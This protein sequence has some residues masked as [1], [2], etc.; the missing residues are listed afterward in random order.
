MLRKGALLFV[1][2]AALTGC[3]V[4]SNQ[5]VESVPAS[6]Q[7]TVSGTAERPAW[8]QDIPGRSHLAGKWEK[9][10]EWTESQKADANALIK[11]W[12][13]ADAEAAATASVKETWPGW[14][15][16]ES[17]LDWVLTY[18][19][20]TCQYTYDGNTSLV[21]DLLRDAG[22]GIKDPVLPTTR[23]Y[24][25]ELMESFYKYSNTAPNWASPVYKP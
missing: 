4:A 17:D 21:E 15:Y 13:T 2:M 14:T 25:P 10:D 19:A 6:P 3:S 20:Q 1:C 8:I 22:H 23:F 7:E 11:S 16:A 12:R 24:C 5:P 9:M 18:G